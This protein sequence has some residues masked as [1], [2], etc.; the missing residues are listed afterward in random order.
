M[1]QGLV[2]LLEHTLE[3]APRKELRPKMALEDHRTQNG[4]HD[5]QTALDRSARGL[6][7][8]IS[9]ELFD[10]IVAGCVDEQLV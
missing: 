5:R 9:E 6:V 1:D 7:Q 2:Q 8:S 4:S 3:L 10:E